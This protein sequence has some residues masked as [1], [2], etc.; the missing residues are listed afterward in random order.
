VPGNRKKKN[1][2][3][4]W[5]RGRGADWRRAALTRPMRLRYAHVRLQNAWAPARY[6]RVSTLAH[7]AESL[8]KRFQ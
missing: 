7:P 5:E 4:H 3:S 8:T 1:H 6:R 2:Y